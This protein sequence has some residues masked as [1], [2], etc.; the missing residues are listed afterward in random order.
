MPHPTGRVRDSAHEFR[1]VA[2]GISTCFLVSGA[3]GLAYEV[4]WTRMLGL[5]FGHTVFAVTTVLAAFMAGLG[6]GSYLFGRIADRQARPLCLYGILEI[7]IGLYALLTPLLFARAE[8]IYIPLRRALGLSFFSFSLAQFC[9]IFAIL[10]VPATLMGATLPVLS[11]FFVHRLAA[12]GGQVG[13][14]Y[15][16]N[17]FG[18]VLGTYLAGFHMI[19]VFGISKSL[20]LAAVANVGIG[21]LAIV[22]DRHLRQ[23]GG[24][25]VPAEEL[26]GR[27]A[28]EQRSPGEV[29]GAPL[30]PGPSAPQPA[31]VGAVWLCVAGLGVSGAA[32]MMYEVAWT[33]SLALVL[34]SSTYAF[35]TMLVTFLA[36]LAIGSYLFSRLAP[37][38]TVDPLLFG[39]LQL[40]IGL[41]AF[42][43]THFF[44]QLPELF[45]WAF[46][47]SQSPGFIRLVHFG[48][49]A[50]AMLLPTLFI[51]ATFPCVAQIAASTL[52][53]VGRDV[54]RVYS[55]NTAGAIVGTV[56]AGFLLIPTWGL[57]LTLK[58]AVT[59]NLC[60]AL[61]PFLLARLPG[62]RKAAALCAPTLALLLLFL[63]PSW[64]AKAMLSGVSIYGKSYLGFLGK[65]N[66]REAVA[67]LDQLLFYEDGISATVSVHRERD[68]LYLRV[69]GKTD[70]SNNPYDMHTQTMMGH[71]PLFFRPEAKR[72]LVVGLG[73]GVTGAAVAVH[74]V[75][76]VDVIE[77]EPAVIRGAAFFATENRDLLRNP[78]V[79]V[80]IAD[81]RNFLLAADAPYDVIISEPSNPWLRGIGNLFSQ[82]FYELAARRLAPDGVICQ[83]IHVYNLLPEDVKM[84]VKTFRSVFPRTTIWSTLP[85]DLLLIGSRTSVFLDLGTLQARYAAT[86]ALRQDL[87]RMGFHSPL[88]ILADFLLGEEEAARY[89]AQARVNTDDLPLLEFSAPDSLYM[90]T[91]DL[92]Q[93]L[94]RAYRRQPLPP[95][96]GL[97][98]GVIGSA[99]FHRDLGLAF[100]SKERPDEALEHFEQTLRLD[101]RDATT[102]IRRGKLYQRRGS[103][104]QAEADFRAALALE[105]G[106]V[107][108]HEA[109]ASL[110]AGQRM[111]DRAESHLQQAHRLRP[112]EARF[113][114]RL[115]DL[116][117][118]RRHFADAITQYR[119]AMALAAADAAPWAGL[120]LAHQG[121]GQHADAIEAFRQALA[122]EPGNSFAQYQMGLSLLETKRLDEALA[123]LQ[124]AVARTPLQVDP[125]LVLA[126]LHVARGEREQAG[127][128]LQRALHLDPANAAALVA[129]EDLSPPSEGA[130]R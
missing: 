52:S 85:G 123:A 21:V 34:G 88:A 117:R 22:F 109:L 36:G 130:A 115:G 93:R 50:L 84:V 80:P 58:V 64:D 43:V 73:S 90:D 105:P 87:A 13:R 95:M 128:A 8:A 78:R 104:L 99:A 75:E 39:G 19:P 3:T 42:C 38:L 6:L 114:L 41:S 53:R 60:L 77:I 107:D 30:L 25:A 12:L 31:A 15:A 120:G 127:L 69:N 102:L 116:S 45:L 79:R 83:W 86:P 100:L 98:E 56:L 40:G 33:R 113:L 29:P 67:S 57:E 112:T 11:R 121:L 74:P 26:G 92:N 103:V 48:I 10:L 81:G 16:I 44:D 91:V 126:R 18:A 70:A 47:V 72:V 61:G 5:V 2:V 17:T 125:Y 51:G 89:A 32:S 27:G 1:Q 110:Y 62:W 82:E 108:A 124:A 7:G 111:P 20:L 129:L 119:A 101:P 96:V 97:G 23:L 54:G 63:V 35:S 106:S 65:A 71:L 94:L 9:L 49:S 4:L 55:V 66:F 28:E 24:T 59:L 46:R 118:E 37:R 14:L 122:R 68:A 76:H